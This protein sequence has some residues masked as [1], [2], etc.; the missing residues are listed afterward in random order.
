M[1]GEGFTPDKFATTLPLS[2][3]RF[4]LHDWSSGRA[5]CL[6]FLLENL[7]AESLLLLCETKLSQAKAYCYN[8]IHECISY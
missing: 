7:V 1:S 6:S 4:K 5:D 3:L 2:C 8:D